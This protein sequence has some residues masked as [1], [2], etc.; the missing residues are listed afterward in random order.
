MKKEE[1]SNAEKENALV[2]KVY[3]IIAVIYF[4]LIVCMLDGVEFA[5]PIIITVNLLIMISCIS[6][7]IFLHKKYKDKFKEVREYDYYSNLDIKNITAVASGILT[8]KTK[9]D[10]NTIITAIYEIGEKNIIE[11]KYKDKKNFL[12]LKQHNKDIIDKLLNYEKS[13]IK[14]IFDS[15]ED[16]NTY[17]LEDILKELE[18]NATK[19]YIVKDIE[20]EIKNYINKKY[21]YNIADY[22]KNQE[23]LFFVKLSTMLCTIVPVLSSVFALLFLYLFVVRVVELSVI[24]FYIGYIADFISLIYYCKVKFIKSQYHSEVQKIY[25]LYAYMSDYSLLKS[26]ELKFY[27]LYNKYYVYAMGLGLADKFEREFNQPTLD[28]N[29]RTALQFYVQNK[30]EI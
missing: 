4:I 22:M 28:N 16:T 14:F 12:T 20:R 29:V 25:G 23:N 30:E 24:L 13:I 21:Y 1:K 3:A 11:I 26:Q 8:K 15:P 27:Q 7:F 9:I 5:F 19:R 17:C 6:S 18:V 10:I 2:Y